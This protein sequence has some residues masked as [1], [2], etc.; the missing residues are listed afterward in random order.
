LIIDYYF[1]G[2]QHYTTNATYIPVIARQMP[3]PENGATVGAPPFDFLKV[4]QAMARRVLQ[5]HKEF[6]Q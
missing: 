3:N 4:E 6:S 5:M 1:F 2:N